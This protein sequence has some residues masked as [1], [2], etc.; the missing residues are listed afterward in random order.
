MF[1]LARHD[2]LDLRIAQDEKLHTSRPRSDKEGRFNFALRDSVYI[3][4]KTFGGR[5]F[6]LSLFYL[7]R[8][9]ELDFSND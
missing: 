6:K 9:L 7:T 8:L 2:G 1:R 5:N 4:T 3:I